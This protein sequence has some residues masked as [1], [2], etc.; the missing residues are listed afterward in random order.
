MDREDWFGLHERLDTP[1]LQQLL[2]TL[3]LTQL[4]RWE[5]APDAEL[6]PHRLAAHLAA[7]FASRLQTLREAERPEWERALL[8]LAEALD[9]VGHP[10]SELA[11]EVPRP[12]PR[13]L[14]EVVTEA[15]AILGSANSV[16]PDVPLAVSALLTGSRHTPSLVSQIEKELAS[17]DRADWLVSFIRFSGIRPLR[18]ALTQFTGQPQPAG[19]PPRL[20][21]ATT[22]YLGATDPRALEFLVELPNTEVRVSYDTHRTRLHA[23]AY[24][25]HR[26]TGFGA[27][28]IGSANVSRVALD[29]GLEWTARVSQQELPHVWR[30]VSTGFEMHWQDPGEFEP[31]TRDGLP[32]FRAAVQAERGLH[33]GAQAPAQYFDLQPYGFQQQMLEDLAAE[34]AGGRNR[35]LVIAA[36]G[37]GKTLLA[38]FDYRA[39]CA[40]EGGI[41]PRLLFLAHRKEILQQAQRS[42]REV[43]RDAGFGELVVAGSQAQHGD[44]LFCSVQS[45]RTQGLD[46]LD[47]AH[48]DYVVIDEAHHGTATSYQAILTHLRPRILLGLTATPERMDGSDIRKDFGGSYSHEL[49]LPDAVEARLLAPFHYFGIEDADNVDLAQDAHWERGGYRLDDLNRILG[50]NDVRAKWVLR[51][52]HEYVAEPDQMRALGFCVSQQHAHFMA[53]W[54]S[55]HGVPSVALTGESPAAERDSAQRDLV[56]RRIKVI[57]T[58]DLY[59]EGVDIPEVD[60]ILLLRPT[61]SL[62]VYL[63]Q[64]GRGLRLHPDKTQLVVLDFIAPQRREFRFAQRFRALSARKEVRIDEQVEKGFP[65]LPSGCLVRL[66]PIAR[67]HVLDNIRHQT[68]LQVPALGQQLRQLITELGRRP[69]LQEMLDFLLWDEP[70]ELLRRGLPSELL[71]HVLAQAEPWHDEARKGLKRGLRHLAESDDPEL[72]HA[73]AGLLEAPVGST[74]DDAEVAALALSQLWGKPR[75]SLQWVLDSLRAAAPWRADVLDVIA[76]RRERLRTGPGR[77]FPHLSGALRLHARYTRE[78]I[79]IALGVS[80]FEQP[81]FSNTGAQRV[82][83]R[84]VDAFFVT[85]EKD[86]KLYSPETMYEDYALGPAE[87]HWQTQSRTSVSSETGQRYIRHR[88][89]NY[90]PLLFVRGANEQS[91]KLTE[92]FVYLGPLEYL[93]HSGNKPINIVWRLS[94][95]MPAVI[96]ELAHRPAI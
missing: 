83:A 22:S 18:E 65:W 85:L 49:R 72:L 40:I 50:H 88:E 3:G 9:A 52:V 25:F 48:F 45:W 84:R 26:R 69:Q 36:T 38:A 66:T 33:Q 55:K 76:W 21:I 13:Q 30:Q 68:A 78:Q 79:L 96:Y 35:H 81:L 94:V 92:P 19:T 29:E 5:G 56:S 34:R 53:R 54:F 27:A 44:H 1:A 10:L 58:V 62:T 93:R 43:L 63:Q 24:L 59:N 82:P 89:L 32:R 7:A 60:T 73:L 46:H 75:A 2:E 86:S 39:F 37:T 71:G 23:K 95:P 4:A 8:Q 87:F 12:M 6:L 47:A 16:R 61:E 80:T 28:Y 17:A 15:R 67:R 31:L 20:R 14:V 64:L 11:P 70:D 77:R 90:T 91:N 41:R 57:F 42:F 74:P 51:Q